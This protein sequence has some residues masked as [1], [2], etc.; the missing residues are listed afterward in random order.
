LEVR[1]RWGALSGCRELRSAVRN[2]TPIDAFS[3]IE[4][5]SIR[6]RFASGRK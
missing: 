4:L 6:L 5:G 1:K 2:G 3:T